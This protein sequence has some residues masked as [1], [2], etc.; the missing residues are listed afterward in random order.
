MDRNVLQSRPVWAATA[1]L[2]LVLITNLLVNGWRLTGGFAVLSVGTAVVLVAVIAR[3]K[4]QG[5]P[6]P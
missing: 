3:A 6:S 2:V 4:K 1:A 5:D